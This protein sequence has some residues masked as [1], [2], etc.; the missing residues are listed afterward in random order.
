VLCDPGLLRPQ[1]RRAAFAGLDPVT[2]YRI[3]QLRSAVFVV[4]QNCA[5]LDLDDRDLEPATRHL[6]VEEAGEPVVCARVLVDGIPTY[7]CCAH[8]PSSQ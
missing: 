8:E 3:W 5:Y 4:E 6:W 2:A 1:I 7:P